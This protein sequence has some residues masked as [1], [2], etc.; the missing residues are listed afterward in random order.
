MNEETQRA[1]H[2]HLKIMCCPGCGADLEL[3]KDEIVCSGCAHRFACDGNLPLL[4]WPNE[5]SASSED[6]TERMKAFYEETPFPNYDDF[7]N[8]G[9]LMQKARQGMFA[10][11]LDD[12]V[13]PGTLVLECG[14][15]TGQL[16]NFLSI[17]N[18]TVIGTDL[19][20]NSLRLAQ[21]FKQQNGLSRAHFLQMNLF[22]PVF[23]PNSFPLVIS[24]GVLHHTSD[25][26]MAFE[27]ISKLVKPGGYILIGLYHRYGRL[28]TDLRRQIFRLSRDRFTSLDPNLRNKELAADKRKAWLFDQYKNPHESK[29][30]IGEVIGWLAKT[31]FS[32]VTSVPRSKPFQPFSD[33]DS[34]FKSEPPG[35]WFERLTVELGMIASGSQEG[36][37]FA[38]IGKKAAES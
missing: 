9:S 16:S 14:C 38:V 25:P 10:K 26:F 28:I 36:G 1:L 6:V 15:G 13:P 11:R 19:C 2:E 8:V 31:G 7:D 37:F 30:T 5:W 29:H 33:N 3:A 4:F 24:N 20:L 35:N 32:F 34:L 17:T 12:Q 22:R 23:K 18:R 21:N 27:S